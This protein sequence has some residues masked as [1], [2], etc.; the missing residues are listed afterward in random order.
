MPLRRNFN[1]NDDFIRGIDAVEIEMTR[2]GLEIEKEAVQYLKGND[3]NVDGTLQKSI[4]HEV[5]NFLAAVKLT[6]GAGANYAL[7][8]H[9]GTKPRKQFPPRKAI[10]RWVKKK[11]GI[12]DAKEIKTV[13]FLI[14]RSI[15]ERGTSMRGEGTGKGPR[16]R[17]FLDFAIERRAKDFELRIEMAFMKGMG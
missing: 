8:V 9:D 4:T 15:K 13:G 14:A 10:E 1:L 6:V 5:E 2:I 12:R 17:P 11:L 3:M 7:F 16:K